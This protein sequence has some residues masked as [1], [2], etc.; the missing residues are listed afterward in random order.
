MT[1]NELKALAGAVCVAEELAARLEALLENFASEKRPCLFCGRPLYFVLIVRPG[2]LCKTVAYS[3]DGEDH[4][5]KCPGVHGRFE[6][7]TPP[8]Q[9]PLFDVAPDALEPKR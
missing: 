9:T 8:Q 4:R 3:E 7:R 5:E 6:A 1:P 2:P